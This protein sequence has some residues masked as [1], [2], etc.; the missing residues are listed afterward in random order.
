MLQQTKIV[1]ASEIKNNFGAIVGQVRDGAFSEVVVENHGEPIVAIVSMG[2]LALMKEV[3]KKAQQKEALSQLRSAREEIQTKLQG[4]LTEQQSL[5]I[6][7]R[8]SKD[9]VADMEK[10]GKLQ[11]ERSSAS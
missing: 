1:S 8:F 3:L 6:A 11:F 4:K 10:E 2:N 7:D 5:A 9:F